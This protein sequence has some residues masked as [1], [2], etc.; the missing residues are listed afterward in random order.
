MLGLFSGTL[1][2]QTIEGEIAI[3]AQSYNKDRGAMVVV[4]KVIGF[5]NRVIR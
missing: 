1:I 2:T 5:F 3:S 4:R